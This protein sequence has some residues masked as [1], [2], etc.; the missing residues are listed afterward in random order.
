MAFPKWPDKDPDE[1]LDYY[2]DWSDRLTGTDTINTSTWIVPAGI[3]KDSDAISS[4]ADRTVIWLSSG[5][6]GTTYE[7]QNRVVTVGGRTMDQ[8]VRLKIKTK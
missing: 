6:E 8:T 1:V 7:V 2:I 3:T 4:P 5:T